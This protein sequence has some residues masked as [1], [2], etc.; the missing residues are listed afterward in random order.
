MRI[1]IPILLAATLLAVP[2][3]AWDV[4]VDVVAHHRGAAPVTIEV[5]LDGAET[6]TDTVA[7]PGRVAFVDVD[8]GSWVVTASAEGFDVA[9]ADIVVASDRTLSLALFPAADVALV[10]RADGAAGPVVGA[11]LRA[12]GE[13]I[14]AAVETLTGDDGS[15]AFAGLPAGYYDLSLVAPDGARIQRTRV[16]VLGDT[17]V[18]FV[19]PDIAEKPR[20]REFRR[21]LC[22]ASPVPG[23]TSLVVAIALLALRRRL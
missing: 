7:S 11:T 23:G 13:R 6:L 18:R 12:S 2:C 3:F 14:P 15:F 20:V 9:S 1:Q 22:A 8:A 4:E 5:A 21:P 10:G 16:D 19:V 17:E